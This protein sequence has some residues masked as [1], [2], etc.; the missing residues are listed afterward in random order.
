[1]TQ[2]VDIS[3]VVVST[4]DDYNNINMTNSKSHFTLSHKYQIAAETWSD[5]HQHLVSSSKVPV[6]SL[7]TIMTIYMFLPITR[8][9]VA[10]SLGFLV[11][12]I[13]IA[14]ST[15]CNVRIHYLHF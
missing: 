15:T 12:I 5:P 14:T 3:L 6:L 10:V 11:S 13:S 4:I 1:M 7:Y 9:D 2:V 8:K